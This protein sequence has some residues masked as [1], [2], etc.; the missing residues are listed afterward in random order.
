[1]IFA[2]RK[3]SQYLV[4]TTMFVLTLQSAEVQEGRFYPD[5]GIIAFRNNKWVGSDHLYNLSNQINV[6]VEIF[7]PKHLVLPVTE[8]MIKLRMTDLFQKSNISPFASTDSGEPSL[9]FFHMLIMVYPIEKGYVAYCEGRLFEKVKLDRV[10]LDEQTYM[11]A[12]TWDSE[13]LVISPQDDFAN[14]LY[15]SVDDIVT[16]F[17]DRFRFYLDIKSSIKKN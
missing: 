8:A 14:Q 12:I 16:T 15:K 13:N 2:L 11:Q 4:A 10:R 9:P 17:T 1:M 3:L 6:S 5:P 7:K